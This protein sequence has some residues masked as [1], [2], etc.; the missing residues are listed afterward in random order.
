MFFV[1]P[2][3]HARF[4]QTINYFVFDDYAIVLELGNGFRDPDYPPILRVSAF[5]PHFGPLR[6]DRGAVPEVED[7]NPAW[8]QMKPRRRK[9]STEIVI[10]RLVAGYVKQRQHDVK[11]GA[12]T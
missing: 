11:F 2:R 3:G 9:K 7:Q 10:R 5:D 6:K 8:A 4:L 12:E 1:D